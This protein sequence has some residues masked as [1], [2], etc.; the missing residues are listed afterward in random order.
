[1]RMMTRRGPGVLATVGAVTVV[2]CVGPPS[3]TGQPSVPQTRQIHPVAAQV[4]EHGDQHSDDGDDDESAHADESK[5]SRQTPVGG[6]AQALNGVALLAPPPIRPGAAKR[7][8]S[9]PIASHAVRPGVA[10][11]SPHLVG[12]RSGVAGVTINQNGPLAIG[13]A[14][15]VT[16][17]QNGPLTIGPGEKWT[18][19]AACP[20]GLATGGGENNSSSAGVVLNQSYA[21]G[22]GSGWIVEVRNQSAS[23]ATYTVYAVCTAGLTNYRTVNSNITLDPGK[24]GRVESDCPEGTAARGT[25]IQAGV[26]AGIVR[27]STSKENPDSGWRG[28]AWADVSNL[29][30]RVGQFAAQAICANGTPLGYAVGAG[31]AMPPNSYL[32]ATVE[33]INAGDELLNGS[34]GSLNPRDAITYLTDSYPETASDGKAAWSVWVRN[35]TNAETTSDVSLF[36]P[37]PH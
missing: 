35:P 34:G 5:P 14:G 30:T 24:W 25:G 4:S 21:Y 28:S 18:A 36:S 16:I 27:Y 6:L 11:P 22:D 26:D 13:L 20:T 1:M 9:T 31:S 10:K 7:T 23:P 29:D 17:N 2:L 32:K 12:A 15:T 3:P 19:A 37:S 33:V 8:G